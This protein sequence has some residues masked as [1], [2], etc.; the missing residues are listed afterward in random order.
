MFGGA[1][2]LGRRGRAGPALRQFPLARRHGQFELGFIFPLHELNCARVEIAH[3]VA[4]F[5]DVSD[6]MRM[7]GARLSAGRRR[8]RVRYVYQL[9]RGN[10]WVTEYGW[11]AIR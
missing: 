11:G 6:E 2:G 7:L 1:V 8:G 10:Y 3:V 9:P 5:G 4:V